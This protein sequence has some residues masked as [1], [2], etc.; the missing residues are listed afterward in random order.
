MLY[1]QYSSRISVTLDSVDI[2]YYLE[3]NT[4]NGMKRMPCFWRRYPIHENLISLMSEFSIES[5]F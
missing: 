3:Q 1:A 5:V 4:G 2:G